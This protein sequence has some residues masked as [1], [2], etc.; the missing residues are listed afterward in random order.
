M[1]GAGRALGAVLAV[2]LVVPCAADA[3][4]SRKES[5]TRSRKK[6]DPKA[7][8][9]AAAS[10]AGD[11]RLSGGES[12][13]KPR[14][15]TLVDEAKAALAAR[16]FDGAQKKAESAYRKQASAEVLF[17]L[18]QVAL[19]AGHVVE[20]HDL[21]RRY[22]ADPSTASD[23][24]RRAEAQRQANLSLPQAGDLYIVGDKDSLVYVNDRLL[25]CLPLLLPLRVAAGN[26]SVTLQSG[27]RTSRGKV[28][29]PAGQARE[30]RFDELTGAVLVSVPPSVVLV[31]EQAGRLSAEAALV[32][33]LE[34][35]SQLVGYSLAPSERKLGAC[36]SLS[37]DCLLDLAKQR[38]ANYALA[39]RELPPS[40]SGTGQRELQLQLWDAQVGDLAMQE[41]VRCSSFAE[42][43]QLALVTEQVAAVLRKGR[44]RPRGM[45]SVTSIPSDAQLSLSGRLVG[46]TPWKGSVFVGP[47]QVE[48]WSYGFERQQLS[49]LVTPGQTSVLSALLSPELLGEPMPYGERRTV[50]ALGA[51]PLWRVA[52]GAAMMGVGMLLLGVGGS[53]L[54]ANGTCVPPLQPPALVCRETIQSATLGGSLLGVGLGLSIGGVVMV[55]IPPRG[56]GSP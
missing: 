40:T 32:E 54:A 5:S 45:L 6:K 44:A 36:E 46:K 17:V 4:R 18:G 56:V 34:K 29:V 52:T 50:A 49:T 31:E 23:S 2:L 22:L 7:D 20:A 38:S 55:A 39:V 37:A 48:L 27:G 26:L 25:G 51:R 24:V 11:A 12:T 13:L 41:T 21:F 19:A 35:G 10:K 8:L 9:G 42:E 47:Q 30:M 16:D 1:R 43:S 14:V 28:E 3:R 33:A 53:A 15:A